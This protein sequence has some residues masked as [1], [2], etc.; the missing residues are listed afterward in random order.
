[1]S[2]VLL[3]PLETIVRNYRSILPS[4]L[5]N[6]SSL[7]AVPDK[8]T[9]KFTHSK[10][11]I[12]TSFP[13][14]ADRPYMKL[15]SGNTS[16]LKAL[17]IGVI[18]SGGPAPG[19]HNIIAGLY[20]AVKTVH[21]DGTVIGF[22]NGGAGFL[23]GSY[24]E[25]TESLVNDYRNT[26]GFDMIGSGRKKIVSS[27]GCSCALKVASDLKL[28]GLVMVGGDGSNT[29]TAV[30]AEYFAKEGSPTVIIGLPKTI[31][32]DLH[33]NFLDVPF[34]FDTA[35]KFYSSIISNISRDALSAKAYYHFIKLMGRSAS[36]IV[37][38]CALQT[39]PNIALIGEE[40]ACKKMTL[41]KIVSKICS[42]IN[43]RASIG[44]YYGIILIPEGI[45]EFIPEIVNLVKE[46]ENSKNEADSDILK[47]LSPESLEILQ[48]FP[49]KIA[50]QLLYDRDAHGN[51]WLSKISVDELFMHLTSQELFANYRD[52]PFNATSHFLGY[53]GRSGLPTRF[54]NDYCYALGF[55][56][57]ALIRN[58][59]NGYLATIA[60]IVSSHTMQ[61][62][63]AIPITS[64]LTMLPN[65]GTPSPLIKKYLVKADS[66]AFNMF[67]IY[68]QIWSLDNSYRFTG[69]LQCGLWDSGDSEEN[70]EIYRQAPATVILNSRKE[71]S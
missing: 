43:K 8:E 37:L 35:T 63:M 44:K 39:H 66:P 62:P 23:E 65:D 53:E 26:G 54:D 70:M 55:C 31:D 71:L 5:N 24:I 14:T 58:G 16:P 12:L 64:M 40:I 4:S 50:E 11:D 38:E 45:I 34:G 51:V 36:H 68:R 28:D 21:K 48:S 60:N 49:P 47:H 6:I 59:L 57:V 56:A 61:Q 20:D 13:L 69:P 19:G 67:K 42:I 25:V 27:E 9:V 3:S 18:F 2:D 52:V 32:G 41:K 29:N 1:M 15:I 30:L 22:L 17:K 7:L 46:I 10:K 33:H